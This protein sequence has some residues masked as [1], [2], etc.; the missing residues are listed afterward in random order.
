MILKKPYAFLIKYFR[1]IHLV[2]MGLFTYVAIKNREVYKFLKKVIVDSA[3]KYNALEYINYKI[4]IFIVIAIILCGIVYFLL[5]YK[6]KPRKIYIFTIIWYIII[7]VFIFVVYGYINKLS[8]M[9]INQKTIRLYRDLLSIVMCGEYYI[10]IFMLVR[11]LGFDIKKFNF[12]KDAQELNLSAQDS[13]EVEV[14]INVD[15]T[16][17]VRGARKQRRELGYF[18][19]EFKIYIL[20]ILVL[21]FGIVGYKMYAYFSSKYKVYKENEIFGNIYNMV[22]RDSYYEIDDDN[23]YVIINFDVLKYGKRDRLNLGNMILMVGDS[24]YTVDKNICYQFKNLGNCYK[25]QYIDTTMKNYIVVYP[26]DNLNIQDVYLLYKES[27]EDE[28]KVKLVMKEY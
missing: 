23:N 26:V 21:V 19:Q 11:G 20:V 27:Y 6:D 5:R 3:Y 28:Y 7:S 18:F 1:L 25:K 2:I 16:N 17:L 13:E 9:A 4:Y 22:I 15:T 14:N 10:I 12:S 8:A 24:N